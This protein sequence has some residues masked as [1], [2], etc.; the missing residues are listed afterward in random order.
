MVLSYYL[1]LLTIYKFDGAAQNCIR[2]YRHRAFA[3]T[4]NNNIILLAFTEIH[5]LPAD[6]AKIVWFCVF[7]AKQS[8]PV[9]EVETS[10]NAQSPRLNNS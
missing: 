7:F 5:E 8:L 4:K 10:R 2:N 3:F 6:E 9:L 1:E